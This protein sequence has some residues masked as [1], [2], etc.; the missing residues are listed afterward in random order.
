MSF[1]VEFD[2]PGSPLRRASDCWDVEVI[3]QLAVV[4]NHAYGMRT[5]LLGLIVVAHFKSVRTWG[6]FN[7]AFKHQVNWAN[8]KLRLERCGA[9]RG[10]KGIPALYGASNMSGSG[11]P[12]Y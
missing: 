11:L 5:T 10:V 4:A 6:V 9:L 3:R 2:T 8:F 1:L 12:A 7:Q